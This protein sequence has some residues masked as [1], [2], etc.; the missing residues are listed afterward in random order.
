MILPNEGN[1]VLLKKLLLVD[2][3]AIR[4]IESLEETSLGLRRI[5]T[6]LRMNLVARLPHYSPIG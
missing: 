4:A 3:K 5:A 6:L 2:R 1:E